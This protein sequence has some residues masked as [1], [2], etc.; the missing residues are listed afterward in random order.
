MEP[1]D[2][3]PASEPLGRTLSRAFH[4]GDIYAGF[5]HETF[6]LDLQGWHSE[7]PLFRTLLASLRPRV[8]VEL[9]TWKGASAL[10]MC[11]LAQELGLEPFTLFCV[12]T[13]LGSR[14]HW[15]E[16]RDAGAF[17][18]LGCR[19][20][21]PTV[22][23]QFLANVV[24]KG[25]Q[26]R[27]VPMPQTTLEAARVYESLGAIPVDLLYVDAGHCFEDVYGDLRAWWPLVRPGGAVFGDDFIPAFPGV[28]QALRRFCGEAG[29]PSFQVEGEKWVIRKEP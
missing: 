3:L 18:G 19:H 9:G 7:V 10:H 22:Y 6:P 29:I 16:R 15:L 14:W 13:W 25:H 28:E 27:I 5:P 1:L 23:F 8:V 4:G 11:D 12:D 21:F 2:T 24:K 20:G 26:D 17:A